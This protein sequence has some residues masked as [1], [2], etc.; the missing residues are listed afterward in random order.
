MYEYP[1][2][3]SGGQSIV[4]FSLIYAAALLDYVV[5]SGDVQAGHDIFPIALRQVEVALQRVGADWL[6]E[7][8]WLDPEVGGMDGDGGLWHFIDCEC[9]KLRL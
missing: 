9:A 8:K 3:C 4:D 5:F 2:I 6:Y 1:Q 7:E